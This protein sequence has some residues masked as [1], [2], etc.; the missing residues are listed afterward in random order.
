MAIL[1]AKQDTWLTIT[2]RVGFVM[3]VSGVQGGCDGGESGEGGN[4]KETEIR[5]WVLWREE[6]E[7]VCDVGCCCGE[8]EVAF[9][10]EAHKAAGKGGGCG[11]HCGFNAGS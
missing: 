11:W 2:G 10:G 6:G 4:E 7:E 8:V 3:G 1:R 9:C 5:R